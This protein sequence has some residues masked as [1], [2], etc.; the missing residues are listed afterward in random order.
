M[1]FLI[2]I[3]IFLSITPLR[4][5]RCVQQL[6]A[7]SCKTDYNDGIIDLSRIIP[8]RDSYQIF[9]ISEKSKILKTIFFNPCSPF[10][11]DGKPD[12][13]LCVRK[14]DGSEQHIGSFQ[15]LKFI[16]TDFNSTIMLRSTSEPFLSE[17]LFVC[18][19]NVDS[20]FQVLNIKNGTY[21]QFQLV[22]RFAC[23]ES[24]FE[25]SIDPEFSIGLFVFL[26]SSFGTL[27]SSL[28]SF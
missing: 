8:N 18:L 10:Q 16:N 12:A 2:A 19:R 6:S 9:K 1:N 24:A 23:P 14:A 7:C 17:V 28:I 25:R 4:G 22:T 21:F 27:L 11:C 20:L 13:A 26:L 5:L 3:I 15:S